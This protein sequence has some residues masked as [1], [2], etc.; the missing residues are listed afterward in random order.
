M[1]QVAKNS[2]NSKVTKVTVTE[3]RV[4]IPN[5][6]TKDDIKNLLVEKND[7]LTKRGYAIFKEEHD[8]K[9]IDKLRRD[10]LAVPFVAEDYGAPP[11]S[12]PVYLESPKKLFIPKHYAFQNIGTPTKITLKEPTKMT[13]QFAGGVR[14]NQM[15]PI[16]NFLD[17]CNLDGQYTAESLTKYSYGGIISLPCGWGKTV[18]GLYL[19]ARLGVKTL[20]IVH[21]E[22]LVNQWKERIQQFLPDAKIGTIQ[23]NKMDVIGKDI[24][25]G[26]LQSVSMKEYPDWVFE[27]FGFTILDECHHLGAEVF[28]RAL[29]KINS[30]YMLGLSATPTRTD[31]LNKVF[32]WYLGPYVFV[33]KEQNTRKVRVNMVYFNNPNPLYSGSESLPNGKPCLARMTN[34]ITEFNRRNE[35]ILNIMRR[36][37]ESSGTHVLA[38]SD[39][40]EHL[41]YLHEQISERNIATVGYYVGGMKDKDLKDSESKRIVL[42]TFTMAAEALD[43]A[44]LNTLILMTSHSGGAVHTQ[45]CGRILRKDHGE[46]TPTIWDIVDDF[47]SYKSQ[48]KKRLD[49]YKKQNYD[50]FKININDHDDIPLEELVAN[51][52]KME[53]VQVRKARKIGEKQEAVNKQ[54][55]CLIGEDDDY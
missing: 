10:L 23:Q 7:Y 22:F 38:L 19:A 54:A 34:N 4:Q 9:Y 25:I 40:R 35:L 36:A 41:K 39:R 8:L 5:I 53:S 27:D 43:I 21:K 15:E 47:S 51:L 26:M 37:S 42:G 13:C 28:S 20:I 16:K 29:P 2:K 48:A 52:D 11:A 44:S 12:F 32:E 3:T 50:I 14:A 18:I 6:Q 46:I 1:S 31:G 17:S 55:V 33:V 49:Y 30:K 45:S 24:C